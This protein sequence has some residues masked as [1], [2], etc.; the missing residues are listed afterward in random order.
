LEL[1]KAGFL[2]LLFIGEKFFVRRIFFASFFLV[3]VVTPA[4]IVFSLAI[5]I[6]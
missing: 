2:L 4:A 5:P 3:L 6:S 1:L